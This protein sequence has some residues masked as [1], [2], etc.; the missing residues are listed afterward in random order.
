[1]NRFEP[2]R[3]IFYRHHENILNEKVHQLRLEL[4]RQIQPRNPELALFVGVDCVEDIRVLGETVGYVDYSINTLQDLLHIK[5]IKID[6]QY[7]HRKVALSVL[8]QL[9]LIYQMPIVPLHVYPSSDLFWQQISKHFAAAGA[10]DLNTVRYTDEDLAQWRTQQHQANQAHE[11]MV[12]ELKASSA[13]E[14]IQARF[15]TWRDL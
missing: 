14:E 6:C 11:K 5:M 4:H 8:W 1:M 2:I 15:E 10:L 7:R 13:W 12:H 9:W 3:E